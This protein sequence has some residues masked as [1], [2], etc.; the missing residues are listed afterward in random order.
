MIR[1]LLPYH[2]RNLAH[3]EDEITLKVEGTATLNSLVDSL[4]AEYPMLQ[5]TIRNHLNQKRRPLL[6]FFACGEDITHESM[7]TP[8]PEAVVRGTEPL[9]VVGAIAGG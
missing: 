2:L 5:G 1:I 4:V 3:V 8:L 7:D 6:R 9:I